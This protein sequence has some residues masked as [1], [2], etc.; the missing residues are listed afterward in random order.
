[1]S[2]D[3]IKGVAKF[4][5]GNSKV[6]CEIGARKEVIELNS[7]WMEKTINMYIEVSGDEEFMWDGSGIGKEGEKLV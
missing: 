4:V 1:M 6:L 3:E 7:L 2:D 5:I